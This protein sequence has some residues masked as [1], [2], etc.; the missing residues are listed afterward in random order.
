MTA[1]V[2]MSKERERAVVYPSPMLKSLVWS[3]LVGH[4]ALPASLLRPSHFLR[5]VQ[6][7][8]GEDEA[9]WK[10]FLERGELGTRR[11]RD[12]E[13]EKREKVT[14]HFVEVVTRRARECGWTG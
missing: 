11:V 5:M 7:S 13:P 14:T 8:V 2:A 4:S 9:F 6:L 3:D 12:L 1:A 10:L